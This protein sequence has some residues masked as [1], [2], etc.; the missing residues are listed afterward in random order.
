MVDD[1]ECVHKPGLECI[2]NCRAIDRIVK[3]NTLEYL[4]QPVRDAMKQFTA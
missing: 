1:V 2:D 3:G 4:G